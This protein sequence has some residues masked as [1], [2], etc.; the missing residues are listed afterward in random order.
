MKGDGVECQRARWLP[1]EELPELVGG[2]RL[3]KSGT[4]F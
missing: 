4:C 1:L 3:P 2:S